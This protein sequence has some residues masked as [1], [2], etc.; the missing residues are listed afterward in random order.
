MGAAGGRFLCSCYG[1]GF[2]F[3]PLEE[4]FLPGCLK[5]YFKYVHFVSHSTIIRMGPRATKTIGMGL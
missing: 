3:T 5:F 1:A 2:L 4:K